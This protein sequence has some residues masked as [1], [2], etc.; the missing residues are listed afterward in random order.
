MKIS[1][2]TEEQRKLIPEVRNLWI[3]KLC[4]CS[5]KLNEADAIEGINFTY[6]L[7]KMEPPKIFFV[8][9]PL[10]CQ[11]LA[12]KLNGTDEFYPFSNYGNVSDYGWCAFGDFFQR[13]GIKLTDKFDKCVKLLNSGV[14]EMLQFEHVCIV[15]KMPIKI[16]RDSNGRLHS[17]NSTAIEWSDGT[18]YHFIHGRS[19]PK[20]IFEGFT[21]TDF[22]NESDEDVKAGMYEIIE[23]AGEGSMLQFLDATLIDSRSFV[24]ANGDIEEMELYNT[25]ELFAEE[26]DLN[27]VS[28]ARLAWLK[29]ICP[30]TGQKYLIPSDGSFTNCVDAAKYHRPDGVPVS[31]DYKWNSR[32]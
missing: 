4:S 23:S 11:K 19:M 31:V 1:K 24:H 32:N 12:N 30:S 28:P 18:G 10:A 13:I 21:K 20:R 2:L 8:D 17:T 29:M 7:A 6:S 26:E 22:I 15:S 16:L 9:S 27:G 5:L 14:Y 3:D 25:K